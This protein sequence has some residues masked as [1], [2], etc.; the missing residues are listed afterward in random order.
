MEARWKYRWL[1]KGEARIQAGEYGCHSITPPLAHNCTHYQHPYSCHHHMQSNVKGHLYC[2]LIIVLVPQQ[3][4]ISVYRPAGGVG[5][6]PSP[7]QRP[8]EHVTRFCMIHWKRNEC[9]LTVMKLVQQAVNCV[10]I[11]ATCDDNISY[12]LVLTKVEQQSWKFLYLAYV[13]FSIGG[14][15]RLYLHV[16]WYPQFWRYLIILKFKSKL[17]QM[18]NSL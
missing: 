8:Q 4:R 7:L 14:R 9:E 12:R 5:C 15:L 3:L 11:Y 2:T 16:V 18:F 1:P 17:R 13:T 6:N 10:P